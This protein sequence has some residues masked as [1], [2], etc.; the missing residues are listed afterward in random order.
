MCFTKMT[1]ELQLDDIYDNIRIIDYSYGMNAYI[2]KTLE[3]KFKCK[4]M[5]ATKCT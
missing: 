3:S 4:T 2:K 1:Q 5:G